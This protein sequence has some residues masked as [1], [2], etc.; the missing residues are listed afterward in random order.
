MVG[1]SKKKFPVSYP[2]IYNPAILTIGNENSPH[3]IIVSYT[4][5]VFRKTWLPDTLL[6]F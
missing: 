4:G 6:F 5:L 1:I 2:I 3:F